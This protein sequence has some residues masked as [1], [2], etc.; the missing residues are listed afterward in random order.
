MTDKDQEIAYAVTEGC[1]KCQGGGGR[2]L[3]EV[4]TIINEHL[5][6]VRRG[7][8]E[9]ASRITRIVTQINLERTAAAG[10]AEVLNSMVET[11]S[12]IGTGA[13]ELVEECNARIKAWQDTMKGMV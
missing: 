4:A 6:P 8:A 1:G 11:M 10:M 9:N 5:N 3:M 12:F 13:D 2:R 7:S